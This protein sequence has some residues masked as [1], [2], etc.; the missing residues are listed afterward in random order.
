[1]LVDCNILP[2]DRSIHTPMSRCYSPA[3]GCEIMLAISRSPLLCPSPGSGL[4]TP[5]VVC[6]LYLGPPPAIRQNHSI[7]DQKL[8]V[9]HCVRCIRDHCTLHIR[10]KA[11]FMSNCNAQCPMVPKYQVITETAR[12]QYCWQGTNRNDFE[13]LQDIS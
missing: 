11:S 4:P 5:A 13:R 3:P 8:P 6:I 2:S 1:M 9:N 10:S 7:S 12:K